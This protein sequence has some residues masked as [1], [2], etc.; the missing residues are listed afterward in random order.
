LVNQF[1]EGQFIPE[2]WYHKAIHIVLFFIV[3]FLVIPI[4]IIHFVDYIL[5]PLVGELTKLSKKITKRLFGEMFQVEGNKKAF[6]Q[7][8]TVVDKEASTTYRICDKTGK[9]IKGDLS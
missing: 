2:R 3:S 1:E 7:Y 8:R 9:L 5:Y 4:L 6:R